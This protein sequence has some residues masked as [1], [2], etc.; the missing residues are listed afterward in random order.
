MNWVAGVLFL[1]ALFIAAYELGGWCSVPSS[2][3]YCCL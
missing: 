2:A 3:V 1:A